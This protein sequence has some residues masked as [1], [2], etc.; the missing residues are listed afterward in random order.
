MTSVLCSDPEANMVTGLTPGQTYY[1]RVYT[2]TSTANGN[3]GFGYLCGY[4]SCSSC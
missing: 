4:S 3:A 1:I 2:Y